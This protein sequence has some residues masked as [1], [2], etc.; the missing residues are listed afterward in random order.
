MDAKLTHSLYM[1]FVAFSFGFGFHAELNK[2]HVCIRCKLRRL[3]GWYIGKVALTPFLKINQNKPVGWF[4][5]FRLGTAGAFAL[6]LVASDM[7]GSVVK[8]IFKEGLNGG[9]KKETPVSTLRK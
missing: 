6:L 2:R 5:R 8:K 1:L 4:D 3:G 7:Q 9:G